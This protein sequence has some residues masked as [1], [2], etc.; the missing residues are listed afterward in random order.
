M[1]IIKTN[2]EGLVVFE[3]KVFKD[4]RGY[5]FESFNSKTW[6]ENGFDLNFIQDN[7]SKSK[8]GTV[9]GLHFQTG[10]FA[11][12][13]L[14]RVTKGKVL[15]VVVDLRDMSP[16]YGQTYRIILSQKNKRQLFIPRGFAHGF[17]TLSKSAIFNYKC[18][19]YY[20][21]EHESG[22]HPLDKK[23]NIDWK[24]NKNE[25]IISKRDLSLPTFD[26]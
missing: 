13:K 25:M 21:K 9:R 26:K 2:I 24:V 23:L 6:E 8:Y 12:A 20:S 16:T 11:Q 1:G 5:F 18:D 14:V 22:I 4:T 19:N 10:S 17:A 15:D 7:E 3:P